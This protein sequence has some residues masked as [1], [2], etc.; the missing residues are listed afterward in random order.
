MLWKIFSFTIPSRASGR[1]DSRYSSPLDRS[2]AQWC[3]P[4]S[5]FILGGPRSF[6]LFADHEKHVVGPA[7]GLTGFRFITPVPLLARINTSF[8]A[9]SIAVLVLSAGLK[10]A[11]T[12]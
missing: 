10:I 3:L 6:I 1:D 4:R 11:H 2:G 5:R 12:Q 9:K 8:I 7:S